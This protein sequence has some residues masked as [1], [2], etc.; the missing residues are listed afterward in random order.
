MN[1]QFLIQRMNVEDH[2]CSER[3]TYRRWNEN[4]LEKFIEIYRKPEINRYLPLAP[5]KNINGK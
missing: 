2:L 3:L 5:V 4:D 1:F